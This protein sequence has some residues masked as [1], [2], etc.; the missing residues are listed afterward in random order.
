MDNRRFFSFLI[1]FF[2]FTY[3]FN[4]FIAPKLFPPPPP[5]VAQEP[6]DEDVLEV[7]EKIA[8]AGEAAPVDAPPVDDKPAVHPNKDVI[9]GS[10]DPASGYFLQVQL[11]S[12]GA[13]IDSVQLTDPKFKELKDETQQVTVVGTNT[14]DDK[15]FT[16][17]VK[18]IDDQLKKYKLTLENIS[19]EVAESDADHATFTFESP[20]HKLRVTK[21]YQVVKTNGSPEELQQAFLDQPAGFTIQLDLTVT[22]L[23]AEPGS[24]TYELQGPV[25]IV[26]ENSDHSRKYRDIKV[27]FEGDDD[28]VTLGG[29]A[30][31]DL[32]TKH[33]KEG[34]ESGI[35]M[36]ESQVRTKLAQ[37]DA[38]TGSFRY[39]GID[40]QF[41]AGLV[42]PLD[43]RPVEEQLLD[44]WIERTYPVMIQK[45][46]ETLAKSDISFR[47]RSTLL[48][49]APSGA[50]GGADSVTHKFAFFVGPKRSVLL[51][52]PPLEATQVL[53]YG[54]FGPVARVMHWILEKLYRMGL[55]YV[56]AIIGLTALVRGCMFPISRK[57]AIMAAKQKALAPKLAELKLK[58]G[59]DKEKFAR[60]QMELWRK[61][62]VN[63]LGGCLP[64][65]IQLPVFIGLYTCL[66]SAV[67]L[68]L[69]KFLWIEN[70]AAPD[71][72]ASMPQLPFLGNE[73]NLLPCISVALFLVQQK[74]FMPPP[75]DDQT[76]MTQKM[77]N[78][79]TIVMGVMFWHVPAGL[80]MYFICSSAW[81]IAE[82]KLLGADKMSAELPTVVVK[83]P[84]AEPKRK[85]GF[86]GKLM[87]AVQEAQ[88]KAEDAQKNAGKTPDKDNRPKGNN[89]KK[90]D[91]KNKYNKKKTDTDG[92]VK[93]ENQ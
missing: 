18:R 22:N 9:L 38:W 10:L 88:K 4:T 86:F 79:M 56:F 76:A 8:E 37:A 21:T 64:A 61:H 12:L 5:E 51:D 34:Q 84:D 33:L 20:D 45:N 32:Y 89:K 19:W 26:L 35:V 40:V 48:D 81:G 30:V 36:T 1:Y 23:S 17:A 57:Q 15:T 28:A 41:F 39:V 13:A 54:W 85:P 87:D 24:V 71:A 2:A 78:M 52:P 25:G 58:Y 63:P 27:E 65:F 75:T 53:D 70:L 43:E 44:K 90:N 72:L 29:K 46:T 82:R 7:E 67:D 60:A 31:E 92:G 66:N 42:A 93:D 62:G 73:F 14:T 3:I 47:M 55:P 68:R 59:E 83:D 11:T 80:C 50:Q 69:S 74:M 77:M 16:T 91:K 6:A 49:L